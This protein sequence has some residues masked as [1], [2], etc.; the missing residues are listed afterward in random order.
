VEEQFL[1]KGRGLGKRVAEMAV[2]LKK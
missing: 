2:F 1:V